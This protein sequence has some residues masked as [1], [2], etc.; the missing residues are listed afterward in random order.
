MAEVLAVFGEL[1]NATETEAVPLF[2]QDLNST[3]NS[4][5]E[6]LTLLEGRLDDRKRQDVSATN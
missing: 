2:P 4:V 5:N 1:V 6:T 3:I